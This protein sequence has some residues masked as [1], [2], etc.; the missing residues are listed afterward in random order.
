[1]RKLKFRVWDTLEKKFILP[2]EGYQGHFVISLNGDFT[3][4]QNGAGGKEC[5]VQQYTGLVDKNG[6][7]IYEGDF[8]NF[9]IDYTVDSSDIDIIEW[10]NQ[11]VHYDDQDAGFFFGHKYEFQM[12]DR[13]LPETIE[14][15]GNIFENSELSMMEE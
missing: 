12:L 6:K 5:I 10:K 3:N 11:E 8:I 15:V 1:M 14:V 7:E 4:L 2:D 13:I 9:K